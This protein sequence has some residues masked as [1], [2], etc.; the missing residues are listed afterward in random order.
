MTSFGML[1]QQQQQQAPHSHAAQALAAA[2]SH[3]GDLFAKAGRPE[4]QGTAL[5]P[6]A[7]TFDIDHRK[8]G[9]PQPQLQVRRRRSVI[10]GL[11]V[12]FRLVWVCLCYT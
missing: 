3:G 1:P 10:F 4:P 7:H 6:V 5:N 11:P 12:F 2:L 8:A 9:M